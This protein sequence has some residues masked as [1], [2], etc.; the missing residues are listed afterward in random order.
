MKEQELRLQQEVIEG[1]FAH[2]V[3]MVLLDLSN[4]NILECNIFDQFYMLLQEKSVGEAL[5][6][7]QFYYKK[8]LVIFVS[9][10]QGQRLTK[11]IICQMPP[12]PHPAKNPTNLQKMDLKTMR[13]GTGLSLSLGMHKQ[14][15]IK[16]SINVNFLMNK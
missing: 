1:Y 9:F 16:V 14:F 6:L 3:V 15:E 13:N 11:R 8:Y 4:I 10:N 2:S 5:V 12:P 7:F